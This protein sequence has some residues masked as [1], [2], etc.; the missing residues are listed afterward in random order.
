MFVFSSVRQLYSE[1]QIQCKPVSQWRKEKT[2]SMSRWINKKGWNWT[3]HE[4]VRLLAR[5]CQNQNSLINT[6]GK[7]LARAHL[8]VHVS[9][10]LSETCIFQTARKSHLEL[11]EHHTST[12]K[13]GHAAHTFF[14]RSQTLG[15]AMT[16]RGAG[17]DRMSWHAQVCWWFK[18]NHVVA[19][20]Q[21]A[22]QQQKRRTKQQKHVVLLRV[23]SVP[24]SVMQW[25]E[26][27]REKKS[28]WFCSWWQQWQQKCQMTT[29]HL[30]RHQKTEKILEVCLAY[31][32]WTTSPTEDRFYSAAGRRQNSQSRQYLK[33]YGVCESSV[34]SSNFSFNAVCKIKSLNHVKKLLAATTNSTLALCVSFASSD[35][36][37]SVLF[38]IAFLTLLA[39]EQWLTRA[40]PVLCPGQTWAVQIF[41]SNY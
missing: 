15:W 20:L 36:A 22:G 18:F 16:A 4:C 34:T 11:C 37:T 13:L 6:Q 38:L 8:C 32:R 28:L 30:L 31:C 10:L 7:S 40:F 33:A 23:S 12:R 17:K 27:E 25:R 3:K 39:S 29:E 1:G 19:E 21:A 9:S 14:T 2:K 41:C 5:V 35:S 24:Y 26:R